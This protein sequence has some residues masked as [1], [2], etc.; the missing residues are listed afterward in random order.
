MAWPFTP[1]LLTA[2]SGSHEMAVQVDVFTS[3]GI[4]A[5]NVPVEGGTITASLLSDVSRS[6][7]L[8][9]AQRFIDAGLFDPNRD[10][11]RISTGPKGWPLIPIFTGR[12]T[13]T[14]E[15]DSGVVQ[16]SVD[17]FGQDISKA[18]F[19]QPW[20]AGSGSPVATEMVRLIR[21]VDP[22]YT[23]DVGRAL[24]G[25]TPAVT[26]DEG[27]AGALDELAAAINCVWQSDRTGGFV[28]Y[29]NPYNLTTPPPLVLTLTD[30][31][32]GTLTSCVKV[33]SRE[34]VYNSITV[35]VERPDNA[36]P[37]RI[38]VRDTDLGSP[39]RWG[40]EFGKQNR[41]VR[42]NTP[43]GVGAASLMAQRLLSQSLGLSRSWRLTTPHFPLLDP[44]D[45]IGVRRRGQITAQVVES[46]TYP[47]DALDATTLATRDL[48]Q[49]TEVE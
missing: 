41:V 37:I 33:S 17:D 21:D 15:P 47:L 26:W 34:E 19:E 44:G 43:A 22:L 27:R 1:D 4:R 29:P 8:S 5:A 14:S 3:T 11:V 46:I 48:R 2:L 25:S 36:P 42:L 12:V 13:Q 28:V 23:V 31:E 39:Y 45:V 35:L 24:A 30:G 40:G 9:V 49:A 6:G 7:G 16:V 38:T 10:R 32:A 18:H 20:E